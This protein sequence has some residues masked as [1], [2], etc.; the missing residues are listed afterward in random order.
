MQSYYHYCRLCQEEKRDSLPLYFCARA[1]SPARAAAHAHVTRVCLR[2]G[3]V[4]S[5]RL[6]GAAPSLAA[7]LR[8]SKICATS[9]LLI[10]HNRQDAENKNDHQ[11]SSV[12]CCLQTLWQQKS[13]HQ[14]YLANNSVCHMQSMKETPA[15]GWPGRQQPA[16]S[17]AA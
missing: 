12:S 3:S 15:V 6:L 13:H 17:P 14:A 5:L 4:R 8:T 16:G 7:A 10:S 9:A 11:Y 2:L 1:C